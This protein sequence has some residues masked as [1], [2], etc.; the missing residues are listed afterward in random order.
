MSAIWIGAFVV[1]CATAILAVTSWRHRIDMA[2]LGTVSD[3]WLAE[4]RAGDRDNWGR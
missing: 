4:H 1:G 3:Q 2:E